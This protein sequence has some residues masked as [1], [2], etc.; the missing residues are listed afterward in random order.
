LVYS[1]V[2]KIYMLKFTFHFF[3]FFLIYIFSYDIPLTSD[4]DLFG[5]NICSMLK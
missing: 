1:L 3:N 2:E 4:D 5:A